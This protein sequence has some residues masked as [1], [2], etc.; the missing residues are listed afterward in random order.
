MSSSDS[1]PTTYQSILELFAVSQKPYKCDY[2]ECHKS[3]ATQSLLDAHKHRKHAVEYITPREPIFSSTDARDQSTTATDDSQQQQSVATT[4]VP[5]MVPTITSTSSPDNQSLDNTCDDDS[6]TD[7]EIVDTIPAVNTGQTLTPLRDKQMSNTSLV[8]NNPC[9]NI[10]VNTGHTSADNPLP[11]TSQTVIDLPTTHICRIGGCGLQFTIE[12]KLIAHQRVMHKTTAPGVSGV[13]LTVHSSPPTAPVP[14]RHGCAH[15]GCGQSFATK[16]AM[17]IHLQSDHSRAGGGQYWYDSRTQ[18]YHSKQALD[19]QRLTVHSAA[20]R[21]LQ[22]PV[23]IEVNVPPGMDTTVADD[24]PIEPTTGLPV[25]SITATTHPNNSDL[26]PELKVLDVK[27]EP[28]HTV[29]AKPLPLTTGHTL[30]QKYIEICDTSSDENSGLEIVAEY[31]RDNCGHSLTRHTT[32]G[33]CQPLADTKVVVSCDI[34]TEGE[35]VTPAETLQAPIPM[36]TTVA[37][38]RAVG[39]TTALPVHSLDSHLTVRNTIPETK[40]TADIKPLIVH[41]AAAETLQA[42]LPMDTTVPDDRPVEPTSALPVHSITTNTDSNNSDLKPDLKVLDVKPESK[43]TVD[44]KPPITDHKSDEKYIEISDTSSDENS[45]LEIVAEYLRD[46]CSQSLTG[47]TADGQCQPLAD[48]KVTVSVDIKTEGQTVTP[49]ATHEVVTNRAHPCGRCTQSFDTVDQWTDHKLT[50]SRCPK[51]GEV[52]ANRFTRLY[53]MVRHHPRP[54]PSD[55]VRKAIKQVLKSTRVGRKPAKKGVRKR[56]P[57]KFWCK[58]CPMR[59]TS[60]VWF[61]K[62]MARVHR[63]RWRPKVGG[64]HKRRR[65]AGPR[66]K[67]IKCP[68]CHVWL[69]NDDCVRNHRVS[70]HSYRPYACHMCDTLFVGAKKLMRHQKSVHSMLPPKSMTCEKCGKGFG[71]SNALV[72]HK[73]DKKH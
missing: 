40:F 48:T 50:C 69:A 36:D 62:H 41:S 24:R 34:K 39:P 64:K 53:H 67:N 7:I 19:K 57:I 4:A 61:A 63:Q 32:D 25:Q 52:F 18:S 6:D 56:R 11:T 13:R 29:D 42:T 59:Y 73:R 22:T 33:Q 38:D 1:L 21:V 8:D 3:F 46:N 45:G 15:N 5:P 37:D 58:Q 35:T 70:V 47:H 10:N 71:A 44:T 27:P 23:G 31:R 26:K 2:N 68:D 14:K 17:R 66:A 60:A 55:W 20:T 51:C 9:L 28:K 65:H 54:K 49:A 43:H 16:L 12:Y 30:D 72:D